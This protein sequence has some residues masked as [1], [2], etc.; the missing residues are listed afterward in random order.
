MRSPT[1]ATRSP[2]TASITIPGC[3]S[4]RTASSRR[5]WSAAENAI[6]AATGVRP[7]G[8]R[9]PGFSLST[10]TLEVLRRR[11]Y[12]YDATVFPNLLNPLARAY[13]FATSNLTAE[14]K[15]QRKELFGTWKDALRP[16]KPFEWRLPGGT[17]LEIP[18]STMPLF[19]V[20]LHL[21]YLLYL[22]KFSR[23][24]ALAY[25][26]FALF[27]CRIT[28][29]QPSVLLHPLDFMGREDC[30]QLAFFP[31]MDLP[32]ERKLALAAELLAMLASRYEIVTMAEH[33]TRVAAARAFPSITAPLIEPGCRPV[34]RS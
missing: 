7:T 6:A 30:P 34:A 32:R 25:F 22:A 1:P 33:A 8:F 10:A 13:F 23:L 26:R 15:E 4:T 20:P 11:G 14:E 29:T 5:T 21:S 16:V 28:G 9:G 18:V 12:R 3:T 31:G 2:I 27:M 24:A 17:L 19:K